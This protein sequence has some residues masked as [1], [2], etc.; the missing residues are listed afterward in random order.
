MGDGAGA[1]P[2]TTQATYSSCEARG[3]AGRTF[4]LHRSRGSQVPR[5][6]GGFR[7]A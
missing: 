4:V 1:R 5:A 3:L 2:T 7:L 6:S